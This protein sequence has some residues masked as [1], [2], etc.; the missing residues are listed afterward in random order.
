MLLLL[1]LF[2]SIEEQNVFLLLK[3]GEF[4]KVKDYILYLSK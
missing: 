4:L 3:K 2:T 1:K